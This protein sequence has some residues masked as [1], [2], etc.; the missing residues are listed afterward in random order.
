[1]ILFHILTFTQLYL[2]MYTIQ[3]H[4]CMSIYSKVISRINHLSYILPKS[5]IMTKS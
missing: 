4:L 5:L 2:S 1:M 3:K